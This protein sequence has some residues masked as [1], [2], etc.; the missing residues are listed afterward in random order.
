MRQR[1]A[2]LLRIARFRAIALRGDILARLAAVEIPLRLVANRM[3]ATSLAS[4]RAMTISLVAFAHLVF[5]LALLRGLAPAMSKAPHGE[6]G[7]R[8]SVARCRW[9]GHLKERVEEFG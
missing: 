7:D 5:V 1:V 8:L 6:S 3:A 4:R 2:D 9:N